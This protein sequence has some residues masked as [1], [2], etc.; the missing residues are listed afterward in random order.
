MRGWNDMRAH[1]VLSRL[2]SRLNKNRGNGVN[3]DDD[4]GLKLRLYEKKKQ[5][6]PRTY[7]SGKTQPD[8]IEEIL[9]AF[10][11]HDLVLLRAMVGSGKSVVGIRTILEFGMGV[12]SV[13]TKVLSDQY[14]A[15]YEG[16]RY[17]LKEDGSRAEIVIM[18]GRDNFPCQHMREKGHNVT[19]A[20]RRIPCRRPLNRE[21]GEHRIDALKECP[22]WGFV[23]PKGVAKDLKGAEKMFYEGIDGEWAACMHGDCE[24][25]AQFSSFQSADVIVMN[26]MKWAAEVSMGRL[27]KSPITVIDEA[28]EWLDSLALKAQITEKRI[29]AIMEKLQDEDSVSELRV[30]WRKAMGGRD[31]FGLAVLLTNM[32]EEIDETSDD[33]FW[34]LKSVVENWENVECE[35]ENDSLLYLV[36]DPKPVLRKLIERVGGKWLMMSATLQSEEVLREVFGIEPLIVE[37]ETNFPGRLIQRISGE[38]VAVNHDKWSSDSFKREYWKNLSEIMSRARR[39]AFIPIHAFKYLPPEIAGKIDRGADISDCG[40]VMMSTKMDRGADLKGMGSIIVT[41]FPFPDM[42]DPL[43]RGMKKRLGKKSFF[44]YYQDIAERCFVQQVGRVLRSGDDVA[45]FWSPDETCHTRLH[46]VWKGRIEGGDAPAHDFR[47][48]K[49]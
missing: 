23:F 25:W 1:R 22:H 41:K 3:R 43:L 2:A 34:K 18:K 16:E 5:L 36:P 12:V 44:A 32:L 27:P 30:A 29:A 33:F 11:S 20:N 39:P 21:A 19:C 8:L 37:G 28:D 13:P 48:R 42:N 47:A 40:G 6:K 49:S 17:F 35:V 14:A 9:E 4:L 15:S 46:G 10:K 24:Y 31:H 26:S 38:E 45:E 7:S